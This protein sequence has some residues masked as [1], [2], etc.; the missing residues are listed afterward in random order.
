MLLV[1]TLHFNRE[2]SP[3]F[4]PLVEGHR[5]NMQIVRRSFSEIELSHLGKCVIM[6]LGKLIFMIRFKSSH[7][8]LGSLV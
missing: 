5:Q 2:G 8:Y 7:K 1:H 4:L 6:F 3:S